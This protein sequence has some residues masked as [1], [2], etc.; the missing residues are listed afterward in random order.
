MRASKMKSLEYR[1]K[2]SE[3]AIK[4]PYQVDSFV[5]QLSYFCSGQ[6]LTRQIQ[7]LRQLEGPHRPQ[8]QEVYQSGLKL[9]YSESL[10]F[11][12]VS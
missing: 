4:L 9:Y 7:M 3:P 6:N 8:A 10:S 2:L 1:Q 12:H 5:A 11:V